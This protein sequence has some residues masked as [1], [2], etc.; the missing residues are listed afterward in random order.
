MNHYLWVQEL[1]C[2]PLHDDRVSSYCIHYHIKTRILAE[3]TSESSC[4]QKIQ[5]DILQTTTQITWIWTNF[6]LFY[7][8]FRRKKIPLHLSSTLKLLTKQ[9]SV[10][11]VKFLQYKNTWYKTI[12]ILNDNIRNKTC[13]SHR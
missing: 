8:T 5:L 3:C 12:A 2:I 7:E 13:P 11:S 1:R 10:S 4:I 9:S 6:H